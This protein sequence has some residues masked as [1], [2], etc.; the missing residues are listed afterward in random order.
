MSRVNG[1]ERLPPHDPQ[2]EQA[3]LGCILLDP[4]GCLPQ[5]MEHLRAGPETFYDLRHQTIYSAAIHLFEGRKVVDVITLQSH[6]R[7]RGTLDEVGGISFLANLP[8]TVHSSLALP[9]YL[10]TVRQKHLMRSMTRACTEAVASIYDYQGSDI[11][12]IIDGI[13]KEILNVRRDAR[14]VGGTKDPMTLVRK[15]ICDIEDMHQ[16]R[17]ALTGLATGFFDFDN[18]TLGLQ[19]GEMIVIAAR[20]SQGKTSLAM[21]IAEHVAVTNRIPVGVFSLEMTAE[22]LIMRMICSRARVNLR[23]VR[24]GFL[25]ERDFPKLTAAAGAV[26]KSP[27][28]I[29]DSSGLTIM[30]LRAKAR[31]MHQKY[32]IRLFIIDYLQLLHAADDRRRQDSRQ[33]EVADVSSGIKGLAKELHVPV[34][35][36]SQLN[37]DLEKEKNRRPRLSDLRESGAIEADADLVGLLY[38]PRNEE[39]GEHNEA[40]AVNL[41]VAK[42]R[43]GP[44]DDVKLTFLKGYTRFESA[45]KIAQDDLPPTQPYKQPYAD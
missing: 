34:M 39:D 41:I 22:S 33:Q 43:N 38:K 16:N 42:Q 9:A 1:Y 44:T 6:L 10:D 27:I 19:N 30:Q 36:L 28:H 25:A 20:P 35:V 7:D 37:R 15:A 17:G 13:E 21:N 23:T 18:L 4:N 29:D 2:A 31:R 24:E 5:C 11:E 3:I 12:Q 14:I 32:G 8:D 26:S 40:E 45:A